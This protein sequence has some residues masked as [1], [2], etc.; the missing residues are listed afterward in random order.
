MAHALG[1]CRQGGGGNAGRGHSGDSG[2]DD[3]EGNGRGAHGAASK[4]VCSPG[5]L[6]GAM[7]VLATTFPRLHLADTAVIGSV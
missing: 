6:P 4:V 7:A 3:D 1:L 2:G 5:E